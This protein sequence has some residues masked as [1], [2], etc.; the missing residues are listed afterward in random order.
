M[1]YL[2]QIGVNIDTIE[3]HHLS[4]SFE[5]FIFLFILE[6]YYKV[7]NLNLTSSHPVQNLGK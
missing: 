6:S 5:Q 3:E 4:Y 2:P 1:G 7:S